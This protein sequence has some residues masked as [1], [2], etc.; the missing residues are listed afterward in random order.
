MTSESGGGEG[1]TQL[2][3]HATT[4]ETEVGPP[5]PVAEKS[6]LDRTANLGLPRPAELLNSESQDLDEVAAALVRS[7]D[8][9]ARK[10]VDS[11]IVR[12]VA[13]LEAELEWRRRLHEF[14]AEEVD[15]LESR[16]DYERHLVM[17]GETRNEA[18][19]RQ[20]KEAQRIVTKLVSASRSSLV[21]LK[22]V[23]DEHPD[24]SFGKEV[25]SPIVRDLRDVAQV[26]QE[27]RA[28]A[29]VRGQFE[30]RGPPNP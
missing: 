11:L 5:L 7:L 26:V 2:D 27:L 13:E 10:K 18:L 24:A 15:D 3:N 22:K 4:L 20:L 16:L 23:R 29:L 28:I 30:T 9:L 19:E 12:R 21:T 6:V 25:L 14:L 17:R 8:L 1:T